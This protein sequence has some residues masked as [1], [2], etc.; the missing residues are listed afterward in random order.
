MESQASPGFGPATVVADHHA[1]D[2][3]AVGG[4]VWDTECL[5]SQVSRE[6]VAFFELDEKLESVVWQDGEVSLFT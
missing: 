2:G 6:K 4:E 3:F 5:E 1:E